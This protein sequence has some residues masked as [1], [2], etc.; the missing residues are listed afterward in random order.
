VV[1][2]QKCAVPQSAVDEIAQVPASEVRFIQ[3][4][5]VVAHRGSLLPLV[6]L[7]NIFHLPPS[8]DATVT[9]L[10]CTGER[11]AVGL[12]VDRVTGQREI[13]IR[14]LADPLVKVPE[15]SGA[16]ELG[17]GR[18]ILILDPIAITQGV[19]RPRDQDA[20]SSSR[21]SASSGS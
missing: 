18:P 15:V 4:V 5:P 13:V 3:R 10:I 16:T 9:M 19:V 11:G 7:R 1:G 6:N 20:A 8:A 2:D 21:L 12:V 17:D 14:P